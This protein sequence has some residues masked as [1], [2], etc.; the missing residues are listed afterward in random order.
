MLTYGAASD[1]V[2]SDASYV[3][4]K[5]VDGYVGSYNRAALAAKAV[6]E[7]FTL[8][9]PITN[10]SGD[11]FVKWVNKTGETVST[12]RVCNVTPEAA[13]VSI[14]TAVY[15]DEANYK[16]GFGFEDL[17][18]GEVAFTTPD[19]S[20]L[21]NTTCYNSYSKS[22][23]R[24]WSIKDMSLENIN[25]AFYAIPKATLTSE[26]DAQGNKIFEFEKD[27]NDNY[28]MGLKDSAFVSE[29]A[30]GDK[31]MTVVR[32]INKAAGFDA[33]FTNTALGCKTAEAD[34]GYEKITYDG[35]QNYFFVYVNDGSLSSAVGYRFNLSITPGSNKGFVYAEKSSAGAGDD[36]KFKVDGEVSTYTVNPGEMTTF[37]V[38]LNTSGE[39]PAFDVYLNGEYA[40]SLPC[41]IFGGHKENLDFSKAY[42]SSF[43]IGAVS[44]A[45]NNMI[46]D[47]ISFK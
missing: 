2:L 45:E 39:A 16:F 31:A 46:F 23:M 7:S 8:R 38:T 26:V 6:G 19:L 1:A 35:V 4:V 30:N 22:N 25:L 40:G 15:G 9:A 43:K 41:S 14:Y 11:Y 29:K 13:G 24:R 12:D 37:A 5:T 20:T 17:A 10:A 42:V 36:N 34:F 27:E 33:S 18:T 44:A 47:N 3:L 32:G 21:T 28:V